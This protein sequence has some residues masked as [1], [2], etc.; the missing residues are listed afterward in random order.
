MRSFLPQSVLIDS[1][2][3]E[4]MSFPTGF[5]SLVRTFMQCILLIFIM[6]EI[7]YQLTTVFSAY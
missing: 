1:D 3:V 2:M 5:S 7:D 4:Y 6:E